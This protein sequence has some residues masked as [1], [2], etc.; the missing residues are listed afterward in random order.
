[1]VEDPPNANLNASRIGSGSATTVTLTAANAAIPSGT[2]IGYQSINGNTA[3]ESTAGYSFDPASD[4]SVAIDYSIAYGGANPLNLGI[5]F[6]IGE[7]G[8]GVNS[9]GVSLVRS[10]VNFGGFPV[11]TLGIAGSARID[12]VTQSPLPIG[13]A[14]NPLSDSGSLFITYAAAT[15]TI[16]VGRSAAPG[17]GAPEASQN[18][19]GIQNSWQGRDLIVS[20]FMRSVGWAGGTATATFQNLRVLSGTPKGIPPKVQS[21]ARSGGLL[22][23]SFEGG[24]GWDYFIQGGPDLVTFPDNLTG[25]S[26]TVLSENPTGSGIFAGSVDV[27]GKG[28]SY[29]LRFTDQ[30]P[31]P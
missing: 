6:G 20:F 26:G 24:T 7:D 16:T 10:V 1:V 23:F 15:G 2:D 17:A 27:S 5:G 30:A 12:D 19:V 8:N 11:T 14:P 9:A 13:A 3:V 21:I 22:D 25:E 29:F 4:F 31:M 28:G 18:F